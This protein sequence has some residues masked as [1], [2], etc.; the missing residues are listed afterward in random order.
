[1]SAEGD[2]YAVADELRAIANLGIRYSTND[3]DRERY[4]RTLALSA[5]VVAALEARPAD[6]V[7]RTYRDNMSHISPLCG[8][9]AAVFADDRILLIRREDNGLWAMPGGLVEVGETLADAAERE[10]WEEAGIRG[11]AV[12]LLGVWDSRMVGSL[13]KAHLFHFCF[14]VEAFGTEPVAG[15]ETTSVGLFREDDLPPLA[16]GHDTVVPSVFRIHRGEL[17]HWFDRS[18]G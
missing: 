2:L 15:P 7:M 9:D 11:Q 16:P 12:R 4:E 13:V 18:G 14:Q 17:P 6:E 5:R 8:A 1:M 10:L 3:Y